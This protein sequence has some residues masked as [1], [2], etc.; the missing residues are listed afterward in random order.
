MKMVRKKPLGHTVSILDTGLGPVE[1]HFISLSTSHVPSWVRQYRYKKVRL[2]GWWGALVLLG[3]QA[4]SSIRSPHD[5]PLLQHLKFPL[6]GSQL[7][8]LPT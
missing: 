8:H 2:K 7:T 4:R 6:A 3:E 5:V 1:G